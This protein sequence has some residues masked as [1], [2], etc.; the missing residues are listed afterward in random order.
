MIY[1]LYTVYLTQST[2]Q[3][4]VNNW[5]TTVKT[6]PLRTNSTPHEYSIPWQ[7]LC[8]RPVNSF[9]K[10]TSPAKLVSQ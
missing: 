6:M 3:A 8:A 1:I 7:L 9:P 5:Q 2:L 4:D 10:Y